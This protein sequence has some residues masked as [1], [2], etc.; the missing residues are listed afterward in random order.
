[1]QAAM[2]LAASLTSAP[3]FL[4]S[5]E[6]RTLCLASF[7]DNPQANRTRLGCD[8]WAWQA[9]PAEMQTPAA[10][11]AKTK[12]SAETRSTRILKDLELSK[13]PAPFA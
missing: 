8:C 6:I 4:L 7:S 9:E 12:A 3:V 1:M 11:I 13:K 5:K 2:I 10:P